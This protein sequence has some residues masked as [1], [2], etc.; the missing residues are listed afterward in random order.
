MTMPFWVLSL[1]TSAGHVLVRHHRVLVAVDDQSR[2]RAGRQEREVVE[3]RGRR[4]RDE[5]LDLG[6]PHQKLHADPGP[7]GEA[8][9]PAAA[10][11]RIDRLRPVERGCRVRQF[12]DA[13]VER[14]LAAPDAAEVEAQHREVPVHEGVVELVDDLVVHR[15]PEL[16]MRM[17]DDGDRRILLSRR[18]IPAFDPS[19]GAGEDD[20][21]HAQPRRDSER[22]LNSEGPPTPTTAGGECR[23]RL[24]APPDR[25]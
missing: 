20:L 22:P 2:G 14:A 25:T 3:V 7:E 15:A 24:T 1:S 4:D 19:S 17:Q 8:G 18:V 16:R 9:D 11:L 13:V 10:R 12:A 6:P 21:G 23:G 5:A